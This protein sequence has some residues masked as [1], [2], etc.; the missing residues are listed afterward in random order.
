M[1]GYS[2]IPQQY[3]NTTPEVQHA[4]TSHDYNNYCASTTNCH[5]DVARNNDSVHIASAIHYSDNGFYYAH[6]NKSKNYMQRP[7]SNNMHT[8]NIKATSNI[9][10]TPSHTLAVE[11]VHM[12]MNN[13]QGQTSMVSSVILYE[14]P[15][16]NNFSTIQQGVLLVY[17]SAAN[18]QYLTPSQ[19]MPMNEKIGHADFR[20]PANYFQP[21]YS[22]V[23]DAYINSAPYT[24][25]NTHI[26]APDVSN[27]YSR[28]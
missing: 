28:N 19:S 16:A 10:Y 20:Y 14:T 3:Y 9:Q 2:Y 4:N 6:H 21:L 22:R 18:S 26:S 8:L 24:N 23:E 11:Q 27:T 7:I 15:C 1:V 17:S 13:Y 12:P 25:I 5:V